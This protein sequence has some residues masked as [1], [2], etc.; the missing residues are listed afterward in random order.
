MIW[1]WY[2]FTDYDFLE[3]QTQ[4]ICLEIFLCFYRLGIEILILKVK[5]NRH[6]SKQVYENIRQ[7]KSLKRTVVINIIPS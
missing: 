4:N 1:R 5:K 7:F 2:K 3:Q 6:F